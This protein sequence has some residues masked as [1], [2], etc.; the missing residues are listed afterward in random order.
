MPLESTGSSGRVLGHIAEFD[1][2]REEFEDYKERLESY[3]KVNKVEEAEKVDLL[4]TL[5]GPDTFH[6]LKRLCVPAKPKDVSFEGLVKK[7]CDHYAPE[8]SV[9]TERFKF[10]QRGQL[11]GE[12]MSEYLVELNHLANS[13]NFP[14]TL[15]E[16]LRDKFVCGL[17]DKVFQKVLLDKPGL[18]YEK[19]CSSARSYELTASNSLILQKE[20]RRSEVHGVSNRSRQS[21]SNQRQ[22]P[23]TQSQ[24]RPSQGQ[25]S[26]S[27]SRQS[28]SRQHRQDQSQCHRCGR[29]HS[30]QSCPA[31]S[32]KCYSCQRQGHTSRM[33]SRRVKKVEEE[34]EDYVTSD[35][36]SSF[37]GVDGVFAVNKIDQPVFVDM[38]ISGEQLRMEVDSGAVCSLMSEDIYREK[39]G[40][41]KYKPVTNVLK[42]VSGAKLSVLGEVQVSV[43]KD[44][45][46][47]KL[48]MIITRS[49]VRYPLLG[50]SWLD[51]LVPDWRKH[52]DVS[53]GGSVKTLPAELIQPQSIG[54]LESM[55]LAEEAKR[56]FP[57]VF[58][59]VGPPI[60]GFQADIVVKPNSTPIFHKSYPV[61]YALLEK[62]EQELERLVSTGSLVPVKKS[63]WASPLVVVPKKEGNIRVCVDFK[64]TVNKVLE[65]EH[66][67]LPKLEDI[68]ATLSKGK[69][70]SVLDLRNAYL[71]L[72]VS[73][74]SRKL[75]TVNSHV[76][77]FQFT[78][79][80]YGIACAPLIFQS[81]MDT[82]LKGIP[83]VCVYID[84]ILI[85]SQDEASHQ[86]TV[87]RV[88]SK[89][90]ECNIR[91]NNSKCIFA[92][93]SV[94]YLGHRIDAQGIHPTEDKLVAI[95][96]CPNPENLKQLQAYLGLLNFYNK[97]LP[98]LSSQ[99]KPLYELEQKG[100]VYNWSKECNAAFIKSKQL[101][102]DNQ[103]LMHYDP[104]L[105]IIVACD[106]SPYGVGAVM[107]HV[108]DGVEKPVMFASSTLST[109]E[110]G[111]A[112]I[113][114]EALAIV[115]AVKRF[116]KF[117]FGRKFVLVSD[118][119]PLKVIF[120]DKTGIP[121]LAA[122]RLQ[123]WAIILSAYRYEIQY[124]KGAQLANAD[125]LSRLPLPERI[126]D[127]AKMS[128]SAKVLEVKLLSNTSQAVPLTAL[129]VAKETGRDPVLAKVLHYT[130]TGW[131]Q[132][133]DDPNLK[134]YFSRRAELS[135]DAQCVTWGN[136]VIIPRRLREKVLEVLHEQHPGVVRSKMLSRS[137]FW[138]PGLDQDIE[139]LVGCCAVCQSTLPAKR[140]VP[141]HSWPVP[142]KP[143]QRIHLD[144]GEKNGIKLLIL[145]DSYSKWLEVWQMGS[146]TAEKVIAKLRLAITVFGLPEV[147]VTDNGPPFDSLELSDY[148]KRMGI[149]LMH[150]PAYHPQSNGLAERSVGVVKLNLL[151]QMLDARGSRS[152]QERIDNFLFSHRNTP[153]TVT[154]FSPAEI[155]LKQRP[156]T[157]LDLLKPNVTAQLTR[158]SVTQKRV[159]D[160][161]HHS[162]H[163][164]FK[165]G[166][167]VWV[168]T[169]RKEIVNWEIGEIKQILSAVTYLVQ[170]SGRI[171][172]IH[173]DHLRSHKGNIEQ[174]PR[175]EIPPEKVE[176]L[177][178][179]IG[180]SPR[181]GSSPMRAPVPVR[182]ASPKVTTPEESLRR[183]SRVVKAPEKLNL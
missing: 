89:L 82:L 4:I 141:L 34:E 65:M 104:S 107:S 79:L 75:L 57:S 52:L 175:V 131:P 148:C 130:H 50:R 62:V 151:K 134:A 132:Q 108:V 88:L 155:L 97:F 53:S 16:T 157:K 153:S 43:C 25:S 11:E 115:F 49:R 176:E 48:A 160:K 76:G 71:Q 72:P 23:W 92:S 17:R 84:D 166:E 7:L 111:Y 81:V 68:F 114:K 41:L 99:L 112:Q 18:T 164:E 169:V 145:S 170:V 105:P 165:V 37:Q 46:T 27:Q 123:R 61:P 125:A 174:G 110:K 162:S 144:F 78:R 30:E 150:S 95:Q 163:R 91:V 121:T 152:V 85:A 116:H 156:K 9:I 1:K 20:E 182:E 159:F 12:S 28:Q 74:N 119:Q 117:L 149:Q 122:A 32:W 70:F 55:T 102:Q 126:G 167:T 8:K 178:P 113:E 58:E 39:F 161:G 3:L 129:D 101:L 158:K 59:A 69:V 21:P 181:V 173:A 47:H 109:A 36:D 66:Y 24:S 87:L 93:S 135:I 124:R 103:V 15:D 51:V 29:F 38:L 172:L 56:R 96:N 54:R 80:P 177:P 147:I 14:A 146:T 83:G 67:V 137:Y 33:C 10:H 180:S 35:E 6:L 63:D 138:W 2:S 154:G 179:L 13:C 19:A 86:N 26:Q 168:K 94:Q 140:P 31:K 127:V 22:A 77:L 42:T 44:G 98:M 5:I 64:V 73:E 139:D 45:Q 128:S 90:E 142:F 106:A 171:R 133:V 136:R 100:V 143:W 120:G 40:N 118:H 183:S 60:V